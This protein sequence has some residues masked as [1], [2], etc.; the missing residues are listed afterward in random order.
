MTELR[1]TPA[2]RHGR[3]RLY[4][5]L[6]DG[7]NIAWYDRDSG[8][9]SLV[10]EPRRADVLAALAPYLTGD[11]TV[12]PPPVPTSAD[13][14]R[15]SLHPD[16]DLA[17]NRPGEALH[18][19]LDR[20]PAGRRL[21]QDPRRAELD[22]QQLLGGELDRLETAGWRILHS[23]PLPGTERID[24]LAIGPAGVLAVHTLPAR[25]LRVRIAD[26]M[27]RVGRAEPGPRLRLARRRAERAALAL[28]AAVR[29]VLAVV[30]AARLDVLPAPPDIQILRED[31]V[32]A[33]TRLGGVLK[34]A[35]IE[36]LY[37][38]ARDRRTWLRV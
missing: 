35:D 25:R 27:V 28:A 15:L 29:P 22:A 20:L 33:L 19:E 23:V 21:R 3:D 37:A 36:A 6:P 4:V 2:H 16:D 31:E 13:L 26:P 34:P 32:P 24:H 9:V 38:T 8:R 5:S 11:V 10:S 14:A 12:G 30:G 1:V 18:A 17:P 7:R